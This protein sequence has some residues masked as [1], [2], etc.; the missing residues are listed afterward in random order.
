MKNFGTKIDNDATSA[1]EVVADEYNSI[2]RELEN[3]AKVVGALNAADNYQLL[4]AIDMLSKA[5]RYT[6]TGVANA[7]KLTRLAAIGAPEVLF[8][9]MSVRFAAA[10]TNTGASTLKLN[11]LAAKALKNN[12]NDLAAGFLVAGDM[13]EAVYD[14]ANDWFE[15]EREI[16]VGLQAGDAYA[17]FGG[18]AILL[19]TDTNLQTWADTFP[20]SGLYCVQITSAQNGL[21]L[22]SGTWYI[23][24]KRFSSDVASNVF[25]TMLATSTNDAGVYYNTNFGGAWS[26]WEG[27]GLGVGQTWQDVKASRAYG[28]TYTNS[29]GR[30]IMVAVSTYTDT[31]TQ[32]LAHVDGVMIA[33]NESYNAAL[34]ETHITVAVPAGSTYMFAVTA[35]SP[36]SAQWSELR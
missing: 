33:S 11:A 19:P 14:A 16:V 23:D 34:W 9:G 26:G 21:P 10:V 1:G 12:G 35:G 29:T 28:V 4:K 6:D 3:A 27:Q 20:D 22:G 5:N 31:Y 17:T 13:Y 7:V 32:L 36:T 24:Y 30:T 18:K 2:F 8:D 15:V 25:H